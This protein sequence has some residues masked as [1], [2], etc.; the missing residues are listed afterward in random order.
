MTANIQDS[1][2]N[3]RQN[4]RKN[5]RQNLRKNLRLRI[6]AAKLPK[7]RRNSKNKGNDLLAFPANNSAAFRT[8]CPDSSN[9]FSFIL[10]PIPPEQ[11]PDKKSISSRRIC[12]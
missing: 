12:L 8:C 6:F 5:V 2:P 3:L 11:K 1:N 7:L 9:S 4:L 10:L